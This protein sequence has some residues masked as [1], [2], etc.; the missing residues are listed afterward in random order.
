MSG[1]LDGSGSVDETPQIRGKNHDID[2][3]ARHKTVHVRFRATGLGSS[4]HSQVLWAQ[5]ALEAEEELRK[6]PRRRIEESGEEF[7]DRK[8]T[9]A[10]C[11]GNFRPDLSCHCNGLDESMTV[12]HANDRRGDSKKVRR[13]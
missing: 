10:R 11:A 13:V 7:K 1:R 4:R 9:E 6:G 2:I 3:F 8:A 12:G 5:P